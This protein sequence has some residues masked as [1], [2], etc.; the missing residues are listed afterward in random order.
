MPMVDFE[1]APLR[2]PRLVALATSARPAW[3]WSA[4]G[5]R[6][7]W[8]NAAGAVALGAATTDAIRERRFGPGDTPAV[9]VTRLATTLPPGGQE[10]LERLRAFGAKF[11]RALTCTCSRIELD[12]AGDAVLI[13]AAET[14]GPVL[15][16]GERVRRLLAGRTQPIAVF[17]P[18]GAPV[19][20]NAAAQA[21]FADAKISGP[22]TLSALGLADLALHEDEGGQIWLGQ[23]SAAVTTEHLGADDSRVVVLTFT[24]RLAQDPRLGA[25]SQMTPETEGEPPAVQMPSGADAAPEVFAS[26]APDIAPAAP[27]AE[28]AATRTGETFSERRHPLRFVWHMDAEGHFG[29]GSDEFVALVGPRTN[30]ALGRPWGEMASE[31]K[32][33]PNNNVARA[34][35]TRET[36]S[37]I[38]V[39]WPVDNWDEC[40]PVELSGLPVFDRERTFRGYRGFG[41]CR[42]I[43]RINQLARERRVAVRSIVQQPEIEGPAQPA[44]A[45]DPGMPVQAEAAPDV[46]GQASP[47]REEQPAAHLAAASAANVVPF[48]PSA[49]ADTKTTPSLSPIERRAF[50][51]LAQ[52][53]TARL[54]APG[55]VAADSGAAPAAEPIAAAVMPAS[56]ERPESAILLDRIPVGILVYR[57]DVLLFA[58]RHFLEWSG[59]GTREAIEAA[60]GPSALFAHPAALTET[61]VTQTFSVRTHGGDSEAIEGR[62]FSMPWHGAPALALVLNN[63]R[64]EALRVAQRALAAAERENY[65]IKS[66]LDAI[67]D[68]IV[69]LD[70]QG[71]IVTANARAAAL[72]GRAADAMPGLSLGELLA[73]ESERAARDYLSRVAIGTTIPDKMLDVAAR[74]GDN[75]LLPLAMTLTRIG[76]DR[77]CA[78]FCDV[79]ARKQSE[80]ELRNAKLEA[81]KAVE[82]KAK[83]LSKISHEIR[84]P[85]NAMIGFAE[86]VKAERFGPIGNERYREYV[87]DIVT[88]GTHLVAMLNDL[89]DLSRI[90]GSK[91]ELNF[92]NVNLNDLTQQ[93]VGIMQPEANRARIIIRTAL[94]PALPQVVADERSL[95]QIVLNLL[96]NSI[97]LTGPGGQVI[98]S[99]VLSDTGEA[100]LRV[101]DTGVGMSET[102]MQAALD[103]FRESATSGSF[104][105]G[106]NGFSLPL[107]KAIAE[108]N[109]AHFSISSAPN[110][111]TL[112]EIAFPRSRVAAE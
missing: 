64:A 107:T 58:N 110:A 41:V 35:A 108:A 19:Y 5:S 72:F 51:E 62:T 34:V 24:P 15:A 40:L 8:A 91:V 21:L 46:N 76:S 94:T 44:R 106:G 68:G 9:Q 4:D 6:I 22:V 99:T 78:A 52:E 14:A 93:C 11:G 10:R 56:D 87:K 71:T 95:R 103:P 70:R 100:V 74:I 112:V 38:V 36:W 54:R 63:G 65:E 82:A 7:L 77:F 3:V 81:A 26:A 109:G 1:L 53:L 30:A 47:G 89:L 39:F 16:L 80:A 60:G 18:G 92:A 79:T 90:E 102:D 66:V 50:R 23:T 25:A 97:K 101:R 17:A 31:L 96:S 84:T 32:L 105:S 67:T 48:R 29:I 45:S 88:A 59:Y 37:G 98:V 42:D 83:F 49:P 69:T 73:A 104:G 61:D 43:D 27:P 55:S 33:D 111:G 86:V 12:G 13:A 85:L 20:A 28:P 2:H 57:D 75:K